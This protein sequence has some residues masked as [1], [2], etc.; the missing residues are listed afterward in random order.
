MEEKIWPNSG[1]IFKNE[2]REKETH[3]NGRGEG[4]V[5]CPH[6][7]NRV[8]FFIDSW[9]KQGAKGVWSSLAFKVKDKQPGAS[10]P[11]GA[12]RGPVGSQ[13]EMAVPPGPRSPPKPATGFDDDSIPF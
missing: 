10:A 6:C 11:Q 2:K 3:A 4:E 7:Q 12:M 8:L 5:T 1:R 9:I 13:A